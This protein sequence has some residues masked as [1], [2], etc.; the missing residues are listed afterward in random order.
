MLIIPPAIFNSAFQL[1]PSSRVFTRFGSVLTSAVMFIMLTL[2]ALFIAFKIVFRQRPDIGEQTLVLALVTQ[3]NDFHFNLDPFVQFSGQ[4][5]ETV[6]FLGFRAVLQNLLILT[7]INLSQDSGFLV[8][9]YNFVLPILVSVG[10]GL[11]VTLSIKQQ[12][13]YQNLSEH[14]TNFDTSLVLMSPILGYLLTE[15]LRCR[16]LVTLVFLG[17]FMKTYTSENLGRQKLQ[18]V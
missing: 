13:I 17:L 8:G 9:L 1:V 2:A 16:G 3:L 12:D 10:L 14:F 4:D 18:T 7:M 5:D 15:S 6:G 11:F